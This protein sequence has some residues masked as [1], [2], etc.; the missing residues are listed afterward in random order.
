[1][2]IFRLE[3]LNFDAKTAGF[4]NLLY[5]WAELQCKCIFNKSVVIN[6]K[7]LAMRWQI[8]TV[9]PNPSDTLSVVN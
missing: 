4:I 2:V 1:M 5:I 7:E 8:N 9:E 6:K 3:N